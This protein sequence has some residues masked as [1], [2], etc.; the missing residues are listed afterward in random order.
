VNET[1]PTKSPSRFPRALRFVR[2]VMGFTVIVIG[3]LLAI[4]GVPGPGFLVIIGGL[5][6]LATEYAWAKRYLKRIKEGGEKV[7]NIFFRRTKPS[8]KS[9]PK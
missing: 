2:I 8:D 3:L 6:I 9:E 7:G 4:P 5:A 1:P